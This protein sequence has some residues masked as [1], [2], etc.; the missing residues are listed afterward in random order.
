MSDV[1][2]DPLDASFRADPYP[3]YARLRAEAP[4]AVSSHGLLV[5]SRHADVSKLLRSADVSR[6]IEESAQDFTDAELP[7]REARRAGPGGSSM[8]NLD[9]PDHS[10]LRGLVSKAFTPRAIAELRPRI[11]QLVDD[12]LEPV[13]DTGSDRA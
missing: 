11:Q 4:L 13:M 5:V 10:R 12:A 1:L 6:N 8:L 7:L 3:T 9:P 2:Y